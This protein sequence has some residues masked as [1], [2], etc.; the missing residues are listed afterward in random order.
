VHYYC[1][2]ADNWYFSMFSLLKA[3]E[4]YFDTQFKSHNI[5]ILNNKHLISTF[6]W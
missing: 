2:L 6:Y 1:L 3:R 4:L 5:Q